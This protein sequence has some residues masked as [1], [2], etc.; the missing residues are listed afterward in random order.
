VKL[1]VLDAKGVVRAC[2]ASDTPVKPVNTEAI[3]VQAYWQQPAL[4]PSAEAGMHRFVLGTPAAR[5]FGG[6]G[7]AAPAP[8]DACHPADAAPAAGARP[9]GQG[10]GAPA[11]L[12]PGEYTVRLTVDGQTYMQRATVK[13]DPRGVPVDMEMNRRS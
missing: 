9:S 10:R 6:R 12:A 3:N 7:P 4:P 11:G 5:G 1:E 13:P 8:Q 2:A